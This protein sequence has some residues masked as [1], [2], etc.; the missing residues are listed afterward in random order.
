MLY[1]AV[2]RAAVAM[3]YPPHRVFTYTL[4][5]EPGTSLRAAGWHLD[6]ETKGG[7]WGRTD[8]PRDTHNADR[9]VRW[10]AAATCPIPP[11]EG[12]A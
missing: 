5:S 3:G 2:R 8:R 7:E 6:A 12:D 11:A 1:S 9:K 10:R 4:A